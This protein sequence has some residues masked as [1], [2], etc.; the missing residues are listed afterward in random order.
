MS[1]TN[2]HIIQG[3]FNWNRWNF[4]KGYFLNDRN[5]KIEKQ[6]DKELDEIIKA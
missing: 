5:K 6:A 1:R 2:K 3:K 4:D